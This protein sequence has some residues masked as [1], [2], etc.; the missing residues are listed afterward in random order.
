MF[1]GA[2]HFD[3]D[4]P[5]LLDGYDRLAAQF[6]PGALQLHVCVARDDGI[7]VFDACPSRAVF[8]D[9]S[10]G[11]EFLGAVSAAGLPR[12]RVELLGDVHA[13]TVAPE[14]ST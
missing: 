1:L 8:T 12:P 10:Q 14:V 7:T 3:G 4:T 5:T 13:A 6:P 9:F 2:Y 11:P